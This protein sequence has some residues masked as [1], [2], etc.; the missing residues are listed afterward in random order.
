MKFQCD[1]VNRC[2]P[3][4]QPERI[5]TVALEGDGIFCRLNTVYIFLTAIVYDI[6]SREGHERGIIYT[7]Y[8][9]FHGCLLCA[10]GHHQ[11]GD[12][13]YDHE[14]KRNCFFHSYAS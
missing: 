3:V 7:F 10:A 8:C 13:Q 6:L 1:G 9:E 11:H 4:D 5:V 12:Q 2:I 14:Y